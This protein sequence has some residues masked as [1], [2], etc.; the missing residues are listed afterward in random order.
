M[1]KY[2][3]TLIQILSDY[4]P[5]QD[6]NSYAPRITITSAKLIITE[7]PDYHELAFQNGVYVLR[8]RLFDMRG[9]I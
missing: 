8:I 6:Q 1:W 9:S 4:E 3:D 2:E 5:P 7:G